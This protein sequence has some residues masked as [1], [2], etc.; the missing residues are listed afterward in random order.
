M[1][2][3]IRPSAPAHVVKNTLLMHD[4]QDSTFTPGDAARNPTPHP[5]LLEPAEYLED[6]ALDIEFRT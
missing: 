4:L 5:D 3:W 2:E 1:L 6:A